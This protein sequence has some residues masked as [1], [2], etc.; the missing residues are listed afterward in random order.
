MERRD[1][2]ETAVAAEL[3]ITADA[4]RQA[5]SRVL[6]RFKEQIGELIA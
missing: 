3:G 5:E 6:R 4:V 1:P 2:S